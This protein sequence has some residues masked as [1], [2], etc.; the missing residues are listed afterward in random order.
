M[1]QSNRHR[2]GAG[3]LSMSTVCLHGHRGFKKYLD[4]K[5]SRLLMRH[6]S[7]ACVVAH[8]FG[9]AIGDNG[10][11]E[12]HEFACSFSQLESPLR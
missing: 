1:C 5:S 7:F 9:N 12:T 8:E 2:A 6:L 10:N 3:N 11:D 4:Y